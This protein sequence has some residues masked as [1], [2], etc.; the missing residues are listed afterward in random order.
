MFNLS[1][2]F[3]GV[4]VEAV[5]QGVNG[6]VV[7]SVT[8]SGVQ[9]LSAVFVG[10]T[11]EAVDQGVNGCVVRSVTESGVQSLSAVFV[12]VTVEA[13]DQ[14][15]NGCVVR[16]VAESGAVA[17]D[18]RIAV[19]DY[20]VSVNNE[21]MRGISSAQSRA[22]LRRANLLSTDITYVLQKCHK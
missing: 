3:V 10:V 2:V 21:T 9:S 12:G 4:T 8:E 16:S 18:G 5:D 1:P 17:K 7:R 15:V 14:G 22:I 11:V 13:V 19:G 20:L 6:C